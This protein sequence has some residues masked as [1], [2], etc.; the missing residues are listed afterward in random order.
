M[1]YLNTVFHRVR[2]AKTTFFRI[3]NPIRSKDLQDKGDKAT[4]KGGSLPPFP[5]WLFGV[6]SWLAA[7]SQW[8]QVETWHPHCP[9]TNALYCPCGRMSSMNRSGAV[10][11]RTGSR[12]SR[13]F[14]NGFAW[15]C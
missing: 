12:S 4:F 2:S 13:D 9:K 6:E 11:V 1:N 5:S 7:F 3:N 8:R 15:L 10:R 14:R